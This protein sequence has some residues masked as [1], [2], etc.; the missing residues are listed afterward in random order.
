M[1]EG[2]ARNS[3]QSFYAGG[4]TVKTFGA[5]NLSQNQDFDNGA[6]L[7]LSDPNRTFGEDQRFWL[8]VTEL[9]RPRFAI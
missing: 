2:D 1:H 9:C 4:F 5:S 3:N 7:L 8:I 6:E